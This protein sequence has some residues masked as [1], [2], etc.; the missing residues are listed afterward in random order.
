MK[1][2][3]IIFDL[4][5]TLVDSRDDILASAHYMLE[6]LNL[7][8]QKDEDIM[9]CVGHGLAYLI[10]G[11]VGGSGP[12]PLYID[13]A[14]NI[15]YSHYSK[16]LLDH[17]TLRDGVNEF[18]R[19]FSFIPMAVLTNKIEKNA[20]FILEGFKIDD[21]FQ[22]VYGGDTCP[23]YKPSPLG[24]LKIMKE[25]GADPSETLIVGDSDVDILTG[26]NAGILTCGVKGGRI[27]NEVALAAENPDW[28]VGSISEL[29]EIIK[30]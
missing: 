20:R 4:D 19:E 2:D 1:F 14:R 24:V 22:L 6:F 17:T 9:A 30:G 7:P 23:E 25:T 8:K 26:K 12:D 5:G 28:L 15:F 18:L 16:H 29:I 21:S 10:R 13:D 27:G 11:I 3:L